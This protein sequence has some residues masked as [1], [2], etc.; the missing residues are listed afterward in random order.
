MSSNIEL[1][2]KNYRCF[3]DSN[4]LRIS[5]KEG[6]IAFVGP[7][8]SGK[9]T[10][11]RF[12]S[13]LRH[14][15]KYLNRRPTQHSDV[16]VKLCQ[17]ESIGFSFHSVID[18]K[19]VF[20]N[21]NDRSITIELI[22]STTKLEKKPYITKCVF[23][24]SRNLTLKIIALID[25]KSKDYVRPHSA[26][27]LV[28][29]ELTS[30]NFEQNAT[31]LNDLENC[32]YIG[33]FRNAINQGSG[34]YFDL[35]VGTT[36]I[37]T[38]KSWKNGSIKESNKAAIEVED[39]VRELFNFNSLQLNPSHD[40]K[41]LNIVSDGNTYRL[42]EVG[43]G[44]S[45]FIIVLANLAIN[46]PAYVL[47]D[48]PELNL[49]PAFQ[50]RFLTAIH[51]FARRGVLFST[52]SIGL[53]R[54]TADQ[55]YSVSKINKA[56]K[57]KNWNE[58][59]GLLEFAGELSY[60]SWPEIGAGKVLLCE[61]TTEVKALQ[62]FLRL[63]RKDQDILIIPMGGSSLIHG[64]S[65]YELGE[66]KRLNTSINVLIDSEKNDE[67]D[68]LDSSRAEFIKNCT[69]LNFNNHVLKKRAFENYL[70]NNAIQ[71]VFGEKYRQLNP[72][73]KL[74]TSSM[75]WGKPNNWKIAQRMTL[76]DLE[77]TDLLDFLE[78]L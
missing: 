71:E 47:I 37:D 3:A 39:K 16:L 38:W 34:Q 62:H 27:D 8:N 21:F 36:F 18:Q 2:V 74:E 9:S 73:E 26:R 30:L 4:P 41:N 78:N 59:K 77:E 29:T 56:S 48:E 54:S 70:T 22:L 31:V 28:Y 52:H 66:L 76:K 63:L 10:I 40:G 55:I 45:Q 64:N 44:L 20:H 50:I 51:S 60:S 1:T 5:I 35:S 69:N 24:I 13:E 61:G 11:L 58:N 15:W 49:H 68:E 53:A 67:S 46:K 7:N 57:V 25:N 72:Y 14:I 23:S 43:S 65:E 6:A 42:D 33:A 32:F 75:N 12:M 19:E 17:G